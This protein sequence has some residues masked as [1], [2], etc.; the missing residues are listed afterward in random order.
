MKRTEL[1][2]KYLKYRTKT[3]LTSY[4]KQRN[5][6]SKLYKKERKKYYNN[7]NIKNITE[8]KEFWRTVKPFLSEKTKTSQKIFITKDERIMSDDQ[9][10][11]EHFSKFFKNAV[12]SLGI[13][14][15][16]ITVEGENPVDTTI[17]T[18]ENH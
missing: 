1:E 3:N 6:C 13:E 7:L 18:F 4:K 14:N 11:A 16:Q 5:F 8:N 17:K 2:T 10:I 9:D 15:N 12:N